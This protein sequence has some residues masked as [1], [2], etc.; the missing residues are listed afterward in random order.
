[1]QAYNENILHMLVVIDAYNTN[2][3]YVKNVYLNMKSK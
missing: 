2:Q 3:I 1:M